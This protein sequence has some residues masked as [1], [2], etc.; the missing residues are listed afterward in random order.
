MWGVRQFFQLHSAQ[1]AVASQAVGLEKYGQQNDG[2][3]TLTQNRSN[4][5]MQYNAKC[6]N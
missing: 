5:Y 6:S 4:V 1:E 3:I 2:V